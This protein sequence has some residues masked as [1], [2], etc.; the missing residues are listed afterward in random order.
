MAR[1]NNIMP[2]YRSLCP[3]KI[4]EVSQNLQDDQSD[5]ESTEE[6]RHILHL[7]SESQENVYNITQNSDSFRD[8]DPTRITILIIYLLQKYKSVYDSA[9][10][11]DGSQVPTVDGVQENVECM[12]RP[13]CKEHTRNGK[14]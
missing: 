13:R 10:L 6:V 11:V 3:S 8:G 4:L 2:H 14:Q 5:C 7:D 12:L 1:H 9:L